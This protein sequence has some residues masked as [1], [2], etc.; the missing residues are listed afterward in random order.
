MSSQRRIAS[1]RANGAR[2]RGPVTPA[3]RA[4]CQAAPLTHGLAARRIVLPNESED[5]FR[6]LRERYLVEFPPQSRR[7]LALIDCLAAARWRLLRLRSLEVDLFDAEIARQQP[8]TREDLKTALAFRALCD[9]S[10]VF[11]I[12]DRYEA[13][14]NHVCEAARQAL[15]R[16]N[17]K[18]EQGPSPINGHC[19][20]R[21]EPALEKPAE[22][23]P[24]PL[25]R[26]PLLPLDAESGLRHRRACARLP[27]A[28]AH[29]IVSGD[30]QPVARL[31]H[32][33]QLP[34]A[35]VEVDALA[36]A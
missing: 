17:K 34:R 26:Q 14:L 3:G 15:E 20:Q 32:H 18:V 29:S 23:A 2:S 5:E 9:D 8:G 27:A 10:R 30:H 16:E 25:L 6:A 28:H 35:Q 11:A 19:G 31:V 33:A 12:L 36:R 24:A 21:A 4:R 7:D 13:H 22:T 1:S